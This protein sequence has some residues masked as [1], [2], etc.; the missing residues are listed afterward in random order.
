MECWHTRHINIKQMA[1]KTCSHGAVDRS[2]F[3]GNLA[4][5]L[6]VATA[7]V[8]CSSWVWLLQST[9]PHAECGYSETF[10]KENSPGFHA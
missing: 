8:D 10:M 5:E 7:L 1:D 4:T 6:S 3:V 2:V 9:R